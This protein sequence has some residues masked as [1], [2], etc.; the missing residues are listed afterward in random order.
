MGGQASRVF[1][2]DDDRIILDSLC[3]FL[4]MEGYEVEGAIGG[5]AALRALGRKPFNVVV[6]DVNMPGSNGF[7]LLRVI[8]Q[9]HPEVVVIIITGY[10]TIESAVEAIKMGAYDYLTKPIID[11]EIRLTIE[12]ALKQQALIRENQSLRQR[13]DLRYGLDNV[14]GHDYKM[15]KVFDL[16]E[17]VADSKATVLIQGES[18]TG[19]SMIAR[20]I[21]H[22]SARRDK[23]FVEVACGA[24][25]EPLLES[26]LFGHV[27]G[28]FTGAVTNKE[29]KFKA[30]DG[31]TLFLDEV[32][33]ASPRLQVKLLRAIQERAFEPVGSNRT[34]KVDVRLILATNVDLEREV[35]E[36]RFRQ[37]LYYRINVV[38]VTLP[39]LRERLGDIPL[40]A[41]TFITTYCDQAQKSLSGFSEE[42][43]QC[44]QSY[45]WPGNVRELENVVERAVVLT[46]GR[47][48][49]MDELPPRLIESAEAA[50]ANGTLAPLPLKQALEGPEKAILEHA[51]RVNG[52]NRQQT[53]EM[54]EINRTTLYKKMKRYGL[55]VDPAKRRRPLV[56]S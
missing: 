14:V 3:E 12:R 20:V 56:V 24:L 45:H 44:L 32:S 37:D 36:G 50:P 25:P 46:K 28:A 13:L 34:E 4:R 35:E 18:G 40:L 6:T 1:V 47:Q 43:M 42:A 39:P 2:V 10:G 31:G 29:G 30:A 16:I 17:A 41:D 15:L 8:R 53:A 49:G 48:L 33:T 7:E 19:K 21:H 11:D 38:N 27:R 52:W 51:L 9:R 55:E 22:R 26:E 23:P 54:L 5:D